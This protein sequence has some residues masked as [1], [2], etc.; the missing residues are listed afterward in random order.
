MG[1]RKKVVYMPPPKPEYKKH[2]PSTNSEYKKKLYYDMRS[3][4]LFICVTLVC[5]AIYYVLCHHF[6]IIKREPKNQINDGIGSVMLLATFIFLSYSIILGSSLLKE[7]GNFNKK[8]MRKGELIVLYTMKLAL[9]FSPFV[10]LSI[11]MPML[12]FKSDARYL[13][14]TIIT[15]LCLTLIYDCHYGYTF[16]FNI[17]DYNPSQKITLDL[18]RQGLKTHSMRSWLTIFMS[19]TLFLIGLTVYN[20]CKFL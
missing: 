3:T 11:A 10:I 7:D 4:I 9:I 2:K 13:A 1:K 8:I 19:I 20:I 17:K 15:I 12:E 14:G 5:I 16:T 6:C 18:G